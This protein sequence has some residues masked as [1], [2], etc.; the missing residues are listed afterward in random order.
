MF[1]F[2]AVGGATLV[3]VIPQQVVTPIICDPNSVSGRLANSPV[4][5]TVMGNLV[6]LIFAQMRPDVGQPLPSTWYRALRCGRKT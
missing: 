5:I 6:T 4:K 3:S 2:I 1:R